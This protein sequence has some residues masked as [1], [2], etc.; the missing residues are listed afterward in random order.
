M[1]SLF[2][3][4]WRF[5]R[6]TETTRHDRLIIFSENACNASVSS[7]SEAYIRDISARQTLPP[8]LRDLACVNKRY[9]KDAKTLFCLDAS[10]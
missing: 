1:G 6:S 9:K 7:L 5:D 4:A 3:G 8:L 10:V 2:L